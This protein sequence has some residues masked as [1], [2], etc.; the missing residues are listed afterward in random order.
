MR[1]RV[2]LITLG[3]LVGLAAAS[4]AEIT[5]V[6][7]KP[8]R[9]GMILGGAGLETAGGEPNPALERSGC[10]YTVE[11][12]AWVQSGCNPA[13]AGH[14]PVLTAS[15]VDVGDLADGRTPRTL[16]MEFQRMPPWGLWP[17]VVIQLWRP[18]CTEIHGA[19]RHTIGS[20][21]TCEWAQHSVAR[22]EPFRIPTGTKWMTL[23]G[24]VTT[25]DLS[26]ALT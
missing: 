15:I 8:V 2:R 5:A 3:L 10:E 12:Q 24:Y 13:L 23:S 18:D 14:D 11:C 22:C 6:G 20:D 21:S 19:K 16:S 17:G 1:F 25:V 26:W 4:S 9:S 7:S